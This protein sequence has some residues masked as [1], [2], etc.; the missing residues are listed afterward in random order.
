MTEHGICDQH[1]PYQGVAKALSG[2]VADG[3][4]SHSTIEQILQFLLEGQPAKSCP[5]K[6]LMLLLCLDML[7]TRLCVFA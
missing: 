1:R 2:T 5:W 3:G 7:P 4:A 6:A